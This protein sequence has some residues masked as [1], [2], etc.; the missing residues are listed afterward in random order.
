MYEKYNPAAHME[1]WIEFRPDGSQRVKCSCGWIGSHHQL[2]L[3]AMQTVAEVL[4]PYEIE[5]EP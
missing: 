5:E 4:N 2:H 1:E 3:A